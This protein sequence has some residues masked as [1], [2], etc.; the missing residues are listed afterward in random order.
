MNNRESTQHFT[1]FAQNPLAALESLAGFDKNIKLAD[2]KKKDC[3]KEV[4]IIKD[5]VAELMKLN[6]KL[7][8]SDEKEKIKKYWYTRCGLSDKDN[9]TTLTIR[10]LENG[11]L[12]KHLN[13]LRRILWKNRFADC[14]KTAQR[15]ITW[16]LYKTPKNTFSYA[17]FYLYHLELCTETMTVF[18]KDSS[19]KRLE[20]CHDKWALHINDLR[21][22]IA[23][24]NEKNPVTVSNQSLFSGAKTE[25][26]NSETE[27]KTQKQNTSQRRCSFPEVTL[28][29]PKAEEEIQKQRRYSFS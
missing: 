14:R 16:I 27:E 5:M 1:A 20:E 10:Q 4:A 6:S 24:M 26:S 19:T 8:V 28:S 23:A 13:D 21:Q 17:Y 25:S 9:T 18:S 3:E 12:K 2:E 22:A 7:S 15:W 11:V 29:K